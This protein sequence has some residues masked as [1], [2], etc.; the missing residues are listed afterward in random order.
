M[1]EQLTLQKNRRSSQCEKEE[2]KARLTIRLKKSR[3]PFASLQALKEKIKTGEK[4][5]EDSF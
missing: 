1:Q 3:N 5:K 2:Q 4:Q